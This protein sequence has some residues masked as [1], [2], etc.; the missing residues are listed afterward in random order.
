MRVFQSEMRHCVLLHISRSLSEVFGVSEQLGLQEMLLTRTH[1]CTCS[2]FG[3]LVTCIWECSMHQPSSQTCYDGAF[4][5]TVF[6]SPQFSA[7]IRAWWFNTWKT[8]ISVSVILQ[9]YC[10]IYFFYFIKKNANIT[11]VI[12]VLFNILF[13]I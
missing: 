3:S 13:I 8:A 2:A 12:F 6:R 5:P 4:K 10:K 1:L 11:T 7:K 9:M